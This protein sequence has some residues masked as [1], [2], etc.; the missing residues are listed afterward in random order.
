MQGG[1]RIRCIGLN[2]LKDTLRLKARMLVSSGNKW[3][4]IRQA[5]VKIGSPKSAGHVICLYKSIN[6]D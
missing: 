3:D 6:C 4:A 2:L 5:L 1:N